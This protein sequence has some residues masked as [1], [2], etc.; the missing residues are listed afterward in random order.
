MVE[1][2]GCS[3]LGEVLDTEL[4]TTESTDITM[5]ATGYLQNIL[6][7]SPVTACHGAF[8]IIVTQVHVQHVHG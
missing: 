2:N 4:C 8:Q 3:L 7:W 1:G 6:K 5:F